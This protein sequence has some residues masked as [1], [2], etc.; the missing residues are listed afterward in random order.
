ML[1]QAVREGFLET[2]EP[3][4]PAGS[5]LHVNADAFTVIEPGFAEVDAEAMGAPLG[6]SGCC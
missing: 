6:G 3:L 1:D 5:T 4:L 2:A